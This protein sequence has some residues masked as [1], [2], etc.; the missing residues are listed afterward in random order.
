MINIFMKF[1]F[2]PPNLTANPLRTCEIAWEN[3]IEKTNQTGMTAKL[4][5]KGKRRRE[6]GVP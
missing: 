1:D 3:M 6:N 4:N 2:F 5:L